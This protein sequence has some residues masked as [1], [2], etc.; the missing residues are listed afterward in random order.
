[1]V[2]KKPKHSVGGGSLSSSDLKFIK[3]YYKDKKNYNGEQVIKA[4]NFDCEQRQAPK[5]TFLKVDRDDYS[6]FKH[7]RKIYSFL[8]NNEAI[9]LEGIVIDVNECTKAK[10]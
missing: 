4:D 1:M 8:P 5:K 9:K 6:F 10:S 7:R 2:Q 3:S